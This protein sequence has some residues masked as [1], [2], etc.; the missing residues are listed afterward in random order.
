MDILRNIVAGDNSH[1]F[2]T[3]CGMKVTFSFQH[4]SDVSRVT[5]SYAM[6]PSLEMKLKM[7]LYDRQ[8]GRRPG[9]DWDD[10]FRDM[11]RK[12]GFVNLASAVQYW[13]ALDSPH[14]KEPHPFVVAQGELAP[15]VEFLIRILDDAP[16]TVDL[17]R[18]AL[19]KAK[20]GY[21]PR[22]FSDDAPPREAVMYHPGLMREG[23]SETYMW[24][25]VVRYPGPG[26]SHFFRN[27]SPELTAYLESKSLPGY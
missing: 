5:V 15:L 6:S 14:R 12:T 13:V 8:L 7:G 17:D 21:E 10:I 11:D 3:N 9:D 24:V 1:T 22:R 20:R 18:V 25:H 23:G 27:R 4:L 2:E 26:F 19:M 16:Y